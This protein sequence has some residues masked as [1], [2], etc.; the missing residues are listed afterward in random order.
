MAV[1]SIKI[2]HIYA[3]AIAIA[4]VYICIRG[5]LQFGLRQLYGLHWY[6][7]GYQ[8]R[9]LG[10]QCERFGLFLVLLAWGWLHFNSA[11]YRMY[12][13]FL[14]LLTLNLWLHNFTDILPSWN[15]PRWSPIFI[16][17]YP[18]QLRYHAPPIMHSQNNTDLHYFHVDTLMVMLS[19][20]RTTSLQISN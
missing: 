12:I 11:H 8:S 6:Y 1:L 2:Y 4:F 5:I 17:G 15:M 19:E 14:N 13:N 7:L 3:I 10:F 16:F 18:R 20:V 9:L